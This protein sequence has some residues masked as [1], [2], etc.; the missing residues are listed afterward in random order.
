MKAHEEL[1]ELFDEVKQEG[2]CKDYITEMCNQLELYGTETNTLTKYMVH[3]KLEEVLTKIKTNFS[4][5]K[6]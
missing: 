4:Y 6:I 1:Y 5:W 3:D 2:N